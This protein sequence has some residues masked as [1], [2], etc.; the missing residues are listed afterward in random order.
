MAKR[1]QQDSGEERV[2]A[3]SRPMMNLIARAP[4]NMSSS[5]SESPGKRSY[6]NQDPWSA[7]AER[8]DR[9]EQPV[10]GSDP[11]TESG[12][13]HE[14]ST[15]SFREIVR[16][17]AFAAGTRCTTRKT[18]ARLRAFLNRRRRFKAL[19]RAKV[20]V[21]R[22]LRTGGICALTY[23]ISFSWRSA[24]LLRPPLARTTAGP[25]L[26]FPWSLLMLGMGTRP[27]Q[28]SRRMWVLQSCGPLPSS[29]VG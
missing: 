2:T 5:T 22:V 21:A 23:P 16:Q 15:E 12:Y 24:G 25:S 13:Y 26:I 3:K 14:Q 7:K 11:R 20:S 17:A 9:T 6:G 28:L 8:E 1:L 4:S 18:K 19:S 27:S 10:V 29:N